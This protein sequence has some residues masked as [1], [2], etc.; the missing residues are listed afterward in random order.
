MASNGQFPPL[1]ARRVGG[2]VPAGLL[3]T[4]AIAAVLAAG[5]DLSSIASI[6]SA[7]AL[8]V[9]ALV[10]AG[11]FSLR[12]ETGARSSLLWAAILSTVV[13]LLAFV[14]TTLVHEPG[15]AIAM[16]VIL[17][18]SVALDWGWKRSKGS[19]SKPPGAD[20]AG[21]HE[22]VPLGGTRERAQ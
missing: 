5:F 21:T 14:F 20:A 17:L 1:M 9:F 13:V 2:R 12:S 19:R 16:V 7:I 11:H 4:A 18:I 3:A 15:T 22:S 6:G 10:T 8:V